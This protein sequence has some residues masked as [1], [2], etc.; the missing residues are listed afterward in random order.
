MKYLRDYYQEDQTKLFE[1]CGAFFAFSNDQLTNGMAKIKE[2]P[3]YQEGDKFVRCGH[4]MIMLKKHVER[5][6]EQS[7]SLYAA[8]REKDIEEN[9]INK[10]ILRE[11]Y[12][13]ECF[14]TGDIEDAEEELKQ[15]DV[16]TEQIRKVY[17]DNYQ[18]AMQEY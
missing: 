9:G 16:T 15:Y 8:A 13:Y 6:R 10:I 12:N 2:T 17:R 11:L 14:Y 7:K 5:Y 18:E 1:E 3:A 4:G